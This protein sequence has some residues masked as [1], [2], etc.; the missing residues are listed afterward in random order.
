M[1][2]AELLHEVWHELSEQVADIEDFDTY[3]E[4]L[5]EKGVDITVLM[6]FIKD[7]FFSRNLGMITPGDWAVGVASGFILGFEVALREMGRAVFDGE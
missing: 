1:I 3:E 7:L 6:P 2:T 4:V 5:R